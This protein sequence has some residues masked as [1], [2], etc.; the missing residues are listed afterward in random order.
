MSSYSSTFYTTYST[1]LFRNKQESAI[2]P[3]LLI[4]GL[5]P[6]VLL[7]DL[8]FERELYVL[9]LVLE[10]ERVDLFV[11]FLGVSGKSVM[12][13]LGIYCLRYLWK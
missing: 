10:L 12:T 4:N 11:S 7:A 2:V 5:F 6:F 8:T 3:L 9:A 13:H 1:L